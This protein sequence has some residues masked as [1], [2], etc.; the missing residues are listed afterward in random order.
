M[1]TEHGLK[2]AACL[3]AYNEDETIAEVLASASPHVDQLLVVDDG[4]GDD[5]GAIAKKLGAQVIRHDQNLGKGVALRDCL[6]W[7][8]RNDVGVLVTLDADGQHDPDEIPRLVRA[9]DA[10]EADIAIGS[11][12]KGRRVGMN[13][14]LITLA[15]NRI[16]SYLLSARFGGHFTDVQTGYRAFSRTAIER[17][18]PLLRSTRFEIELEIF[19]KA[20]SSGLVLKEVPVD[21]HRRSGGKTKFTFF[22][23]MRSLYFAFKYILSL[24]SLN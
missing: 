10:N 2:V 21:S 7:A 12:I 3:L 8:N 4:S 22:L 23:R 1:T 9:I 11:R 6:D 24:R 5:T 20:K 13:M 15:S 17:I 16:I 18:L 14:D 19:A